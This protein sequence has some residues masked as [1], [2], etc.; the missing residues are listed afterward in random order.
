FCS[1]LV[2]VI[3]ALCS[4]VAI[5]VPTPE[6]IALSRKYAPQWRFHASEIYWPSTVEYFLSGVKEVD[7][8]GTAVI[9]SVTTSNVDGA[10]NHGSGLYLTT[11]VKAGKAGS[12]RGQ[13]P[14]LTATAAYSFVVPKVKLPSPQLCMTIDVTT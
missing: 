4:L 5:A 12:L 7:T 14:S 11:D 13:N 9:G 1:I 2:S 8:K 10:V 3:L 6:H